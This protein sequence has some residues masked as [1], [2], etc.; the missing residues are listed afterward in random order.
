MTAIGLI[1]T[2]RRAGVR[3]PGDLSVVGFDDI[4]LARYIRPTL[5]TVAQPKLEMG[6][7]AMGMVLNLV[8]GASPDKRVVSDVIVQGRLVVRESSGVVSLPEKSNESIL[9]VST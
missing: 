6:Q 1:Q 4:P 7:F 2:A 5:T 9:E 8:S 3:V